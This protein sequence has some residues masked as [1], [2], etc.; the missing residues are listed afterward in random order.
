MLTKK[1]YI[2]IEETAIQWF[3][4]RRQSRL[5]FDDV[6]DHAILFGYLTIEGNSQT[7]VSAM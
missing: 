6:D 3:N 2:L 5:D 7:K 1:L 4:N